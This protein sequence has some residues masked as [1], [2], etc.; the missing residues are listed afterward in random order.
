M[1]KK[2]T[3]LDE[4]KKIPDRVFSPLDSFGRAIARVCIGVFFFFIRFI[5]RVIIRVNDSLI[6]E[7][8]RMPA[9]VVENWR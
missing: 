8:A 6:K 5:N 1:A 3:F 7:R 4:E 9:I 2:N